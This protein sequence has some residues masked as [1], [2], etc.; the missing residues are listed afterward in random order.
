LLP[1]KAILQAEGRRFDPGTLHEKP[2]QKTAVFVYRPQMLF[3]TRS[4]LP[5]S[6][7]RL[8]ASETSSASV[9]CSPVPC[10][11]VERLVV[12]RVRRTHE[13]G[14]DDGDGD[15]RRTPIRS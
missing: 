2:P 12:R 10:A 11:P 15:H 13:A 14:A 8:T 9:A 6:S 5:L 4:V 3:Y 1:Y 7:E